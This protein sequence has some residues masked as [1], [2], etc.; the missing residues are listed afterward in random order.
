MPCSPV[1]SVH[2]ISLSPARFLTSSIAM[3]FTP[4]L[5]IIATNS[6]FCSACSM[7]NSMLF[8]IILNSWGSGGFSLTTTSCL[9]TLTRFL[10][11]WAPASLY[12]ESSMHNRLP[13][14]LSAKTVCPASTIFLTSLGKRI[15]LT[16]F[17]LAVISLAMPI[18]IPPL[19]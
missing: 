18:F 9:K 19:P 7:E 12:S 5:F 6:G 14:P 4:A 13:R 16:S 2:W 15:T 3:A 11:R 17:P 1:M 10:V 8:L